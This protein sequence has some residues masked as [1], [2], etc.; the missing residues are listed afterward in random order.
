MVCRGPNCGGNC[1]WSGL[2]CG[3]RYVLLGLVKL[4][5]H[6]N[7]VCSDGLLEGSDSDIYASSSPTIRGSE[8]EAEAEGDDD[9]FRG[10]ETVVTS[11]LDGQSWSHN[12]VYSSMLSSKYEIE[13]TNKSSSSR[14]LVPQG[15]RARTKPRT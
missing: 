5:G 15:T 13:C 10:S 1:G 2:I 7:E 14:V 11:R 6:D 3:L 12:H 9:R 8:A 4:E